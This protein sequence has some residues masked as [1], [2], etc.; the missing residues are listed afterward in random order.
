[1]FG[2]DLYATL[3]LA[4][5]ILA[6]ALQPRT[7]WVGD[8]V[9]IK[10]SQTTVGQMEPDGTFTPTGSSRSIQYVVTREEKAH[11]QVVQEG[12][13][14]W[15][16]KDDVVRIKDAVDYFTKMLDQEPD[17]DQW[18]AFRGWARFRQ[19]KTDEAL[20]D[21]AE[22]IRLS[23]RAA[24]WY[25]NRGLIYVE[26]KKLDE[27]IADFTTAIDLTGNEIGYR[28]RGMAYSRKKDFAK[29]AEDYAKAVELN[30]DSALNQNQLAWTLAT[31]PDAKV[32]DGKRALEAAK[33]A[34]ELT[35]HKNGGY[36][37][38]LAAAY[39]EL[40][41]FD[42]AVQWQEKALQVGDIPVKDQD[43]ARK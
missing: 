29:A 27:A 37:D 41:E 35:D 24:S 10:K 13:R 19:G 14:V 21:Y 15:V 32:R 43:G 11:V 6:P 2:P 20:K 16:A 1:M 36:L 5:S 39:A 8:I 17:N 30:P 12:K 33:K 22:A 4:A 34:C 40:G 18:F 31:V 26:T 28:H 38:T 3:A 23:P 9:F 42:K 7:D 25:G